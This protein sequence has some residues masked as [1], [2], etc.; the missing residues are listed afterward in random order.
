MVRYGYVYRA[1]G[2]PHLDRRHAELDDCLVTPAGVPLSCTIIVWKRHVRYSAG[3]HVRT[4]ESVL[5]F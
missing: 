5:F 4:F 2:V 1:V 3:N